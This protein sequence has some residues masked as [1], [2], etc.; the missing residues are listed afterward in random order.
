[1]A[2]KVGLYRAGMAAVLKST[3]MHRAIQ[4]AAEQVAANVD[5]QGITV[6]ATGGPGEIDLPVRVEMTTTDRAKGRVLL[7]HPAGAAVQAKHG[8]LT[9]AAV[10]AGLDV[11]GSGGR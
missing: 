10:A 6:G 11:K 2:G 1:M 5:A 8:A 9:K 3:A 4:A 7:A